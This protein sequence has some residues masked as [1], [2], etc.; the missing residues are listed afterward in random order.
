VTV[1]GHDVP[2]E[3][4]ALLDSVTVELRVPGDV[5]LV[6]RGEPWRVGALAGIRAADHDP[7]AHPELEFVV[8]IAGGGA[9]TVVAAP[10]PV[11]LG[12]AAVV[13]AGASAATRV[14]VYDLEGQLV[15]ELAGATDGGLRWDL[16]DTKGA[17]VAAGV[18]LYVA[19]DATGTS[20]GRIAIAR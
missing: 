9:P 1:E 8:R 18:Y 2:V 7:L 3:S 19:R 17:R 6:G 15:R 16:H 11:R 20:Q 14:A 5:A 12:D 13:F 10:N 4:V